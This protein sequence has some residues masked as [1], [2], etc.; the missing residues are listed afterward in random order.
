MGL[1]LTFIGMQT[2][3]IVVPDKET[4]VTMG[5]LLGL[6]PVLAIGGLA[7][8]ASLHYRNVRGSIIIGV[9]LTALAYFVASKSWPTG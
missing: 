2:S 7:V 8:I 5:N 9:M 6:E 4:M 3:K 1:L